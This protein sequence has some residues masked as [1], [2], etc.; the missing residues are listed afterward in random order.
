MA[1]IRT[2]QI[3]EVAVDS[4]LQPR[5]DGLNP[6][7]VRALQDAPDGWPPI[8]VAATDGRY[9]LVDGFHRYAAAQNLGL[10]EIAAHVLP[11]P[12]DGDLHALA[13][14][15]NAVHGRPL[16][17]DDRRAFA[18]RLLTR[19]PQTSNMEVSRRAGLS[20]TTIATIRE[21][22]EATD[23]IEPVV[24]R[25]GA[26]GNR[27]PTPEPARPAGQLPGV[28]LGATV[29]QALGRL[30]SPGQRAQQ[31]KLAQYLER[32][33]VALDD[34][35]GLDGWSSAEDAAEACRLVLGDDAATALGGRVGRTSGNVLDVALALGYDENPPS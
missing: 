7:Q 5:I 34:Q 12:P 10:A 4:S 29:G 16:S 24:E 33:A 31:R 21:R 26:N 32:L 3:D 27:Y 14:A 15:L 28:G 25:I 1:D 17:L 30:I 8:A 18:A 9:L 20:P 13:F 23:Q 11:V 22:L 19:Q 6:E 35:D 2:L